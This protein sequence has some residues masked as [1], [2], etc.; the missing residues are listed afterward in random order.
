M[1]IKHIVAACFLALGVGTLS[2]EPIV[3]YA[4]SGSPGDW[5][6][7]FNVENT[8]NQ[9]LYFFGVDLPSGLIGSPTGWVTDDTWNTGIDGGSGIN[10]DNTWI[11]LVN[12]VDGIPIGGSLSG[13]LVTDTSLAAPTSVNWFAYTFDAYG[14]SPYTGSDNFNGVDNPGFEGV[15]ESATPEPVTTVLLAVA[16]LIMVLRRKLSHRPV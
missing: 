10:Y 13:Y 15:A 16:V 11:T 7:D 4:V 1:G 6:L 5:T 8:T 2:A 12:G 14:G 3:T 9:L